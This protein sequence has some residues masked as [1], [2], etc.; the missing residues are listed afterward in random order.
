MKPSPLHPIFQNGTYLTI[1][2]AHL[3]AMGQQV[4]DH[5][6]NPHFEFLKQIDFKGASGMIKFLTG[7]CLSGLGI[8]LKEPYS[9]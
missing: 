1:D 3:P 9:I 4:V 5:Y 8:V 7:S 2:I 6:S